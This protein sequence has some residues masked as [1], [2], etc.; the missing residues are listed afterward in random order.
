MKLTYYLPNGLAIGVSDLAQQ[1][2]S[3][4]RPTQIVGLGGTTSG[5]EDTRID[6][7]GS[8]AAFDQVLM[9][10]TETIKKNIL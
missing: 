5:T 10:A 7:M 3:L 1:K 8:S 4:N 9:K 6:R 2:K